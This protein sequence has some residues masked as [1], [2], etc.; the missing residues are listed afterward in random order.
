M[1]V[2]FSFYSANRK[3][4]ENQYWQSNHIF[5]CFN[6]TLGVVQDVKKAIL[7]FLLSQELGCLSAHPPFQKDGL[8]QHISDWL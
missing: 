2:C 7:R 1:H 6:I 4:V 3:R 8:F 5:I